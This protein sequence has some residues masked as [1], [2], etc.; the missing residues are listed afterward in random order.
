MSWVGDLVGDLFGGGSA[1]TT[2][3]PSV[4]DILRG[5]EDARV[6]QVQSE[7]D[8]YNQYRQDYDAAMLAKGSGGSSGQAA[9]DAA[10]MAQMQKS[11][12]RVAKGYRQAKN[13]YKPF[14]ESSQRMLPQME[15][16]YGQGLNLANSAMGSIGT[17][18]AMNQLNAPTSRAQLPQMKLPKNLQG[19]Q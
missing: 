2:Q 13:A 19:G 8:A 7:M 15:Q 18:G 10:K 17:Q 12:K 3:N 5:Q 16:A 14:L 9:E 1:P 4:A 6:N 11:K